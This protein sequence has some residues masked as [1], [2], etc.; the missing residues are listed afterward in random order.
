MLPS[1]LPARASPVWSW[2][3]LPRDPKGPGLQAPHLG[4]VHRL[5]SLGEDGGIV[6]QAQGLVIFSLVA[7]TVKGVTLDR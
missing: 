7:A 4:L 3:P 2:D 5:G 6:P 1:L